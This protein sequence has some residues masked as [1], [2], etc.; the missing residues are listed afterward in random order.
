MRYTYTFIGEPH[1]SHPDRFTRYPSAELAALVETERLS[2][3]AVIRQAIDA[4][5][6]QHKRKPGRNV[7]GLWKDRKIDGLEYQQEI[8]S[9]W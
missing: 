2:R 8:R 4:Y 7:F 3:V 9:E 6:A 5:I 1:E